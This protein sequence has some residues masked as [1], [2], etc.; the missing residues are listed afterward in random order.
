[1][2][3]H[4]LSGRLV[5]KK[6]VILVLEGYKSAGLLLLLFLF[7]N[8]IFSTLLA[9]VISSVTGF[10][11]FHQFGSP[12]LGRLILVLYQMILGVL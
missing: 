8:P 3:C 9:S 2:L 10:L 1:M 11:G 6:V 4:D 12:D 7:S 5:Q